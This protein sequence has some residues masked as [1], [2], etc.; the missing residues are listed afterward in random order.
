MGCRWQV[1]LRRPRI[2]RSTII[3][4]ATNAPAREIGHPPEADEGHRPLTGPRQQDPRRHHDKKQ[5]AQERNQ[6]P[7]GPTGEAM[8]RR[9]GTPAA[10]NQRRGRRPSSAPE[11]GAVRSAASGASV[12]VDRAVPQA[13]RKQGRSALASTAA[14]LTPTHLNPAENRP[15]LLGRRPLPALGHPLTRQ[16]LRPALHAS[17]FTLGHQA[18][19]S[20]ARTR[21]RRSG[22]DAGPRSSAGWGHQAR[23]GSGF[24][25]GAEG[26][27]RRQGRGRGG[28]KHMPCHLGAA[29]WSR[30]TR[31]LPLGG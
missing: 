21:P 31:H 23:A 24:A 12:G 4:G 11:H 25:G 3:R 28:H 5:R 19:G 10:Q 15:I 16:G 6:P 14:P 17:R 26:R 9:P 8:S 18:P 2:D 22:R 27:G 29:G 30:H 13:R 20:G 1:G 7:A